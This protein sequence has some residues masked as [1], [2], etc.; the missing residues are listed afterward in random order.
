MA[1]FINTAAFERRCIRSCCVA[2]LRIKLHHG[3]AAGRQ[4]EA[5]AFVEAEEWL[6]FPVGTRIDAPEGSNLIA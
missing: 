4:I 3:P 6:A 5:G 2:F 1:H